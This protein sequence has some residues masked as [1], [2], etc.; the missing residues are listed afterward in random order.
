M[1]D[2]KRRIQDLVEDSRYWN[3]EDLMKNLEDEMHRL[4][5]GLGQVMF[6]SEGRSITMCVSPLPLTPKFETE[7]EADTLVVKIHLPSIEKEDI[8]LYVNRGSVEVRAVSGKKMC[9]PYYLSVDT[10]WDVDE[11]GAEVKFE[12]GLLTVKAKRLKKVRVPVK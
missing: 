8:R 6:D 1:A 9:R 12:N 10:P 4:E 3:T 5:Q 2:R 11:E 7:E